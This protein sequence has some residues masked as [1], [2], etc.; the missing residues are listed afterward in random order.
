M[1]HSATFNGCTE[2]CAEITAHKQTILDWLPDTI[3]Q[4][5]RLGIIQVFKPSKQYQLFLDSSEALGQH[6]S[7][8]LPWNP[9]MA[10]T[11]AIAAALDTGEIQL[12]EYN[13][14]HNNR[15]IY[16][17]ARVTK[18]GEEE[19]LIIVRDISEWR[20]SEACDLLLLDIAVKV[21]EERSLKE[22]LKLACER[23]MGI[24]AIRLVWVEYKEPDNSV[25]FFTSRE[26]VAFFLQENNINLVEGSGLTATVLRTGKFQLMD[27]EDPRMVPWREQLNKYAVVT[28]AAFPLKVGGLILGAL[29][30]FMDDRDF[31]T[32]RTIVQLTNLAEQI[33]IA[34]HVIANRQ[35]LRLLT[36]G[37]ESAANA[38][39][40][41]NRNGD[42]QWVNPAFLEL[43]GYSEAEIINSNVRLLESGQHSRSFYKTM[44]QYVLSGRIWCGEII[45]RRKD[46]SRY[47]AEMTITPVRDETGK[48]SNFISIIQ[49]ITQRKQAES[50]MLEAQ[51]AVA[52]AERLSALGIMAAG[53][54]HEINQPLNALKVMADGMLYWYNKGK[55][56][57]I[58]SVM[59]NVQ[60]ISKDAD[61]IDT[62]IKHMRSFIYSSESTAP[63]PCDLNLA[64]EES[65]L[66]LGSQLQSH[67]IEVKTDL[68]SGMPPVLGNGTQLEQIIINLLVNAMHALDTVDKP[69]KQINILTGWK[70][71]QVFLGVSDN[72][73]GISK[74]IKGKIFDPFFTTKSV[75]EG[76]GLG[77][78]VVHSIITSYGGKIS[79]NDNKPAG[80]TFWI[81]F[82]ILVDKQK[83]EG[84]CE[85][86]TCR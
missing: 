40:I 77:L 28:G 57:D 55:I 11:K 68:A 14:T 58:G 54:A 31:W 12:F 22:I 71:G 42:I 46:D 25:K 65:L 45:N 79:V 78:S 1:P 30:I 6:I 36:T 38:I 49:D 69:D 24:F 70:K 80:V 18:S 21:Q 35:R 81:E 63:K 59:K 20:R 41:T 75:G 60:E 84:S 72:G 86:L 2:S 67:N 33:A 73:P 37:L 19:A 15:T 9:A 17:E 29:T 10:A 64:V 34:I 43:N 56:P 76:M 82:P 62:I 83:G 44:W 48:I 26:E 23:I 5:S 66:L 3:F 74:K 27:I 8:I 50:E 61:R 53:I 47:T 85:H 16:L 13:L 7:A 39:V 32:K 51:E 52:Q 4:V